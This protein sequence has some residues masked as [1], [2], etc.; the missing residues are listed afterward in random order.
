[1][2]SLISEMISP[3]PRCEDIALTAKSRRMMP[4]TET[5]ESLTSKL[6]VAQQSDLAA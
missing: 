5:G 2:T 3:K 6:L 4:R 1:M